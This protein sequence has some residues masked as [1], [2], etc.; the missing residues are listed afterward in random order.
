[1]VYSISYKSEPSYLATKHKSSGQLSVGTYKPI[2]VYRRDVVQSDKKMTLG[3]FL[4]RC[5]C[6]NGRSNDDHDSRVDN[7]SSALV[8]PTGRSYTLHHDTFR[9]SVT[10]RESS[11][12]SLIITK[13]IDDECSAS[14]TTL[15]LASERNASTVTLS[16]QSYCVKKVKS[17]PCESSQ[18]SDSNG[19]RSSLKS[20]EKIPFIREILSCRDSFLKS[21]E[22]CDNTLTRGKRCR[23]VKPDE[24]LELKNE[25]T[26]ITYEYRHALSSI[27]NISIL[28]KT[29]H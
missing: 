18:D 24:W 3:S 14:T 7:P 13:P 4:R 15:L 8:G 12:P 22:W 10:V 28:T 29:M 20:G 2:D 27:T 11:I 9:P 1:M 5:L 21:L 17:S 26:G 16:S 23:L 25:G 19:Q 6:C